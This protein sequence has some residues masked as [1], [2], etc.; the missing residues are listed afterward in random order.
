LL[1]LDI[2]FVRSTGTRPL[3]DFDHR[4]INRS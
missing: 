3:R 1:V 4:S 2:Y